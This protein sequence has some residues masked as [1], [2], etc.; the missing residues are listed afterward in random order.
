MDFFRNSSVEVLV[1]PF[2]D[3]N[4][5]MTAY[6]LRCALIALENSGLDKL[7]ACR[8]VEIQLI[9]LC[10]VVKHHYNLDMI[11]KNIF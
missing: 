6:D 4:E 9:I 1:I 3:K 8:S 7:A 2:C 11:Y 5:I 10:I